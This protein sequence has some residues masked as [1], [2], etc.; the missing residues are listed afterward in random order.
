MHPRCIV[1]DWNSCCR[2]AQVQPKMELTSS[3]RFRP[4]APLLSDMEVMGVVECGGGK[5]LSCSRD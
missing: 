2:V 4:G 3:C 5:V 1:P